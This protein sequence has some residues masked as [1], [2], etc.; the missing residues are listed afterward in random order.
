MSFILNSLKMDSEKLLK[1]FPTNVS[2][3]DEDEMI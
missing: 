3:I 1:L 2:M